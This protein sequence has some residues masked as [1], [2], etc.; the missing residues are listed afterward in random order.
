MQA[1]LEDLNA[2]TKADMRFHYMVAQASQNSMMARL[3]QTFV[4]HISELM[5]KAGPIRFSHDIGGK[6][7][8]HE[9]VAIYQAILQHDAEQASQLMRRHLEGV[10]DELETD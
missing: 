7:T 5:K 3:L 6:S 1:Q 9:H 4:V 8:I 10:R 2:Y